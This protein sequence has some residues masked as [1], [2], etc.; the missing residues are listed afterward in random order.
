[1]ASDW[2]LLEDRLT[3]NYPVSV[4]LGVCGNG[5]IDC[6]G[7]QGEALCKGIILGCVATAQ[8]DLTDGIRDLGRLSRGIPGDS[9]IATG[10]PDDVAGG[11]GDWGIPNVHLDWRDEWEG[12][13]ERKERAYGGEKKEH[14]VS[15]DE[16]REDE[17]GKQER[18]RVL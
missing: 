10:N 2:N 7:S 3:N 1:M 12:K 5:H 9:V 8:I 4:G 16:E 11:I 6:S 13:D 18:T 17:E 15:R 14:H